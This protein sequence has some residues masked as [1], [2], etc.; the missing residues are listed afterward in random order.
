MYITVQKFQL[1]PDSEDGIEAASLFL[2]AAPLVTVIAGLPTC[3]FLIHDN[4]NVAFFRF[5]NSD[6][7][8]GGLMLTVAI[9]CV[10]FF[11]IGHSILAVM[12]VVNLILIHTNS[13]A[14]WLQLCRMRL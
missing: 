11:Y 14:K 6:Q 10:F 8:G 1:D 13:T 9:C 2:S 4:A 5:L 3:I 7:Y 12:T